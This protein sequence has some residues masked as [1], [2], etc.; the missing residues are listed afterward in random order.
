[1]TLGQQ[2]RELRKQKGMSIQTLAKESGLS[3]GIISQ[4]ERDLTKPSVDTLWNVSKTLGVHISYFFCEFDGKKA[5]IKKNER[6]KIILPDSHVTYEQLS[7]QNRRMEVLLVKIEPGECDYD[8]LIAHEGEEWGYV[9]QGIMKI[10]YGFTD[11]IL[12]EGDSIYLDSTIPHRYV[13]IGD[14]TAISLWSMTPASY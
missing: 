12:Y 5:V 7:P 8:K 2:I 14:V 11:Y 6:R 3:T 1:M 13:N 9:I 4:M 10:K